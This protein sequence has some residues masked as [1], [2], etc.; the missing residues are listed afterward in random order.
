MGGGGGHAGTPASVF[1]TLHRLRVM[2]PMMLISVMVSAPYS[3]LSA[4]KRFSLESPEDT[5]RARQTTYYRG[6]GEP[7]E[8]LHSAHTN[9]QRETPKHT[10]CCTHTSVLV[11]TFCTHKQ[12]GPHTFALTLPAECVHAQTLTHTCA[13][14]LTHSHFLL[15]WI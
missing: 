7:P 5:Q 8:A 4:A 12:T 6:G 15:T 10:Q 1:I 14:T 3:S 9:T 11:C 2:R 13:P